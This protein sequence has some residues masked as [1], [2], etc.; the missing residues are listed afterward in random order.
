MR[1]KWNLFCYEVKNALIGM[2]RHPALCISAVT[3]IALTLILI[4][5]FLIVSFHVERFAGGI[6]R[7]LTIHAVLRDDIQAD[8]EQMVQEQIENVDNVRQA[9][10]SSKDDELE[11][12]ITEKGD[13]FAVY[14]GENNPLANA[15][16]VYVE[17][18]QKIEQTAADLQALD[19]VESVVY[20]GTSVNKLVRILSIVRQG[21]IL[22]AALMLVLSL[23]LIYNTIRNTIYSRQTEISVM[24]TVGASSAFVRIPFQIEGVLLG[25]LGALIPYLLIRWGYPALYE[26]FGGRLFISEFSLMPVDTVS[27]LFA[28]VLFGIGALSGLAAATLAAGRTLSRIR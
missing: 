2:L 11:M 5:I 28:L 25:L 9:V 14:R 15:F 13:A 27:W 4:S 6:G 8:Q 17:D 26:I 20:G 19:T 21:C 10:F 7:E 18:E 16:Y 23:Y 1:E 22:L 3:S 24:K 12:M